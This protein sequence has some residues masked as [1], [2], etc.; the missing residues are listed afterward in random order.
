LQ[1]RAQLSTETSTI[2]FFLIDN[3][4]GI[5]YQPSPPPSVLFK[6]V[7]NPYGPLGEQLKVKVRRI[8]GYSLSSVL[9]SRR[10]A[11]PQILRWKMQLT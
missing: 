6:Y 1:I 2:F 3:I 7:T 4:A 8:F 9:I 5:D 10:A 11:S